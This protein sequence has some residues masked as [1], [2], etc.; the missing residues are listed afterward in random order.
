MAN[1]TTIGINTAGISK[2]KAAIEQYKNTI[3]SSYNKIN[4]TTGQIKKA[5]KGSN[6][7]T[8]LTKMN[9]AMQLSLSNLLDKYLTNLTNDLSAIQ[10][11]YQKND[12]SNTSFSNITKGIQ[13]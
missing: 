4:V 8:T 10:T 11:S 9:S 6:S 7:V 1:N 12:S 13:N 3:K 2:I 5:I